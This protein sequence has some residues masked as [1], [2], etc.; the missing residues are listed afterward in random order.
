MKSKWAI[1]GSAFVIGLSGAMMPGPLLGACIGYTAERGFVAGGPLLVLGHALLELALVM[2]VLAGIG[3]LLSRP[4]VGATIGLVGGAVL[5]WM[6][7]GMVTSA[8][9]PDLRMTPIPQSSSSSSS[10]SNSATKESPKRSDDDEDDDEHDR[11][12]FG[13][14]WLTNPILAGIL[15]SLANPYW[16][17]WWATIGLKYIAL[18]RERANA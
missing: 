4:R 3:P 13:Q 1:F 6:G 10:S 15:I 14:A 18:S 12:Q 9:L 5:I 16:S 11:T 2:L 8:F 7:Y 17:L